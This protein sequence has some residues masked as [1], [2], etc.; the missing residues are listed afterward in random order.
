MEP[1]RRKTDTRGVGRTSQF[2]ATGQSAVIGSENVLEYVHN[3]A[4]KDDIS[5]G[6]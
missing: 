1:F 6:Y 4:I 2:E 3:N 5:M